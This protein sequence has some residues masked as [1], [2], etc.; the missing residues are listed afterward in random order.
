MSTSNDRIIEILNHFTP[1]DQD[2]SPSQ[3]AEKVSAYL[4]E[5]EPELRA[6]WHHDNEREFLRRA[7]TDI[8][9][10]RRASA[11]RRIKASAFNEALEAKGMG[12][13]EPLN[14]FRTLSHA[15]DESGLRRPLGEMTGTDFEFVAAQHESLS[16][17]NA[18][19]AEFHR[20]LARAC[21]DKRLSEVMS[22]AEY[23]RLYQ[24]IVGAP[25]NN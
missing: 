24:S 12:N 3:V 5:T 14:L 8:L 22:E 17:S 21:G 4:A 23:A 16:R 6:Q 2:F 18:M 1:V 7:L 15:V 9:R 19:L 25:A 10:S 11:R 13:S 20:S